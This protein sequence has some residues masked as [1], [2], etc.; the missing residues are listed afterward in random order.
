MVLEIIYNAEGNL[1]IASWLFA[2]LVVVFTAFSYW[3]REERP[4]P[5]FKLVGKEQ[6]EWT[7]AKAKERYVRNAIQILKKGMD[8]V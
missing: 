3:A 6:G 4:Y 8:E 2:A 7:N 5:G 1:H